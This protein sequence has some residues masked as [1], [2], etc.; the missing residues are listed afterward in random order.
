MN[1]LLTTGCVCD[2]F[3]VDDINLNDMPLEEIKNIAFK[4]LDAEYDHTALC[5]ILKYAVEQFGEEEISAEC[6]TC[7]TSYKDCLVCPYYKDMYSIHFGNIVFE[8]KDNVEIFTSNNKNVDEHT[9]AEIKD[10]IK[11][12]VNKIDDNV[13]LIWWLRSVV[14]YMGKYKFCYHCDECGD[15]VV[16]YKLKV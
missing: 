8:Q 3:T 6:K 11:N 5:T 12:I 10:L 9:E 1:I 15:N 2:A 7:K 4:I 13:D 16:E 14:Q